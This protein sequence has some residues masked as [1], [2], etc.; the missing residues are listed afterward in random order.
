M[1]LKLDDLFVDQEIGTE[2]V[3]VDFYNGSKLKIASIDNPKYKAYLSKLARKNRFQLDQ[4]NEDS[5][6]LVQ[7][8]TTD[9]MAKYV[10]VGWKGIQLGEDGVE[11]P[12]TP[13][14]GKKALQSAP[15]LRAFVS[16]QAED[17]TLYKKEVI[18]AVKKPSLGE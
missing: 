14:I 18:E 13:E 2:G 8:I 1:A 10:L 15:K 12:Y 3:W 16:E 6:E 17:N 5:S 9:A 4:S 11:T 7:E